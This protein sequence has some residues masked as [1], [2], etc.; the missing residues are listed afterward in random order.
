MSWIITKLK[1]FGIKA[2]I[3]ALSNI[4]RPLGEK[5]NS[6]IKQFAEL[7]GYGVARLVIGEIQQM[8]YAYFNIPVPPEILQN[9]GIEKK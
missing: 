4:E 9:P 2:A 3:Q 8:L 7:D 5:I 6:G 1:A